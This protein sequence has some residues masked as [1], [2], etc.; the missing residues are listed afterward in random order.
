MHLVCAPRLMAAY[1]GEEDEGDKL[2]AGEGTK[3]VGEGGA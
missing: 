3:I 1:Q 2:G